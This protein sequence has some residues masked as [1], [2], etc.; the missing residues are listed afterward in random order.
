MFTQTQFALA[1][2]SQAGLVTLEQGD[3][4]LRWHAKRSADVFRAFKAA[5]AAAGRPR[6]DLV[7]VMAVQSGTGELQMQHLRDLYNQPADAL[8]IASYFGYALNEALSALGNSLT[9][10]QV[11]DYA[12]EQVVKDTY[13]GVSRSAEI[14]AQFGVPLL[15]Y[16]GGQHM[17]GGGSCGPD[18]CEDIQWLQNL[19]QEA[20]RDP[21]MT[22]LYD[23]MFRCE[24][25]IVSWLRG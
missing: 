4:H 19:F 20:N 22:G 11:L 10:D 3:G 7:C 5:F 2:G 14:A 23:I 21:R 12:R 9:I 16:E 8:A 13:A 24:A 25:R 18:R 17:G 6:S 15:A 1:M